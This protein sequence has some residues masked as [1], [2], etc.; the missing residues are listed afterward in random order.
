VISTR[1]LR[2]TFEPIHGSAPLRSR[3]YEGPGPNPEALKQASETCDF[4]RGPGRTRTPTGIG[5]G[6]GAKVPSRADQGSGLG[7]GW[8]SGF[9]EVKSD[10]VGSGQVRLPRTPWDVGGVQ[11]RGEVASIAPG[12]SNGTPTANFSVVDSVFHPCRLRP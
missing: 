11:A 9:G 4:S 3:V 8:G 6:S 12:P 1:R 2:S 5:I 7:T 10:R